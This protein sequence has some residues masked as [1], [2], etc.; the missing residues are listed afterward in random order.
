M[1]V[2]AL[3]RWARPEE[4]PRES[5]PHEYEHLAV[6]EPTDVFL[7]ELSPVFRAS[8]NAQQEMD[9]AAEATA[10]ADET[11]FYLVDPQTW[12]V[13][14]LWRRG[15][16]PVPRG[17]ATITR[18][19]EAGII[20][21]GNHGQGVYQI[22]VAAGAAGAPGSGRRVY[23]VQP[24]GFCRFVR[25]RRAE[26]MSVPELKLVRFAV[27]FAPA[28]REYRGRGHLRNV[29]K[30]VLAREAKTRRVAPAL[31]RGAAVRL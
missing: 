13:K 18:G 1:R 28:T 19:A 2:A 21:T 3:A 8:S 10:A 12:E 26:Y 11:A 4:F 16:P 5:D 20:A 31:G 15:T 30:N 25:R 23:A 24:T 22:G 29:L 14:V 9:D 27:N 17:V 6:W 7:P